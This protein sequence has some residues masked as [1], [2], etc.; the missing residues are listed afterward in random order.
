M[1]AALAYTAALLLLTLMGITTAEAK[2]YKGIWDNNNQWSSTLDFLDGKR[3]TYCFQNQCHTT[4]YSGSEKGTVRFNWGAA[5]FTLKWNGNA[6]EAT[7]T[8]GGARNTAIL[9]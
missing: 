8:G 5:R 7:R 4:G 2:T 6:Y 9:R 3:V 1:R